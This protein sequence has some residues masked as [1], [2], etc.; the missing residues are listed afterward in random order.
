[1]YKD[2]KESLL[3]K[4]ADQVTEDKNQYKLGEVILHAIMTIFNSED[5]KP[6]VI[7]IPE[8]VGLV[9]EFTPTIVTEHI[10]AMFYPYPSEYQGF[11]VD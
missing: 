3:F 11:N 5:E 10:V 7:K 2:L 4:I 1:M 8:E 6:L 9:A